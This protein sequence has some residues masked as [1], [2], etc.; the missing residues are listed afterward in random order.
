MGRRRGGRT[1]CSHAQAPACSGVPA[2]LAPSEEAEN[3]KGTPAPADPPRRKTRRREK[4]RA[5]RGTH[6]TENKT[7]QKDRKRSRPTP[8]TKFYP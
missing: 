4:T 7:A 8:G 5:A 1:E 2:T 6:A 3:K